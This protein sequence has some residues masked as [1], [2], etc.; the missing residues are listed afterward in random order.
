MT[1]LR[2]VQDSVGPSVLFPLQLTDK[3]RGVGGFKSTPR[4]SE[5]FVDKFELGREHV[6]LLNEL[7]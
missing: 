5:A 7:L 3:V 4:K 1:L 2:G 6:L